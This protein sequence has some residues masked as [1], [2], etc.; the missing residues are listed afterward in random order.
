MLAFIFLLIVSTFAKTRGFD[1]CFI[2]TKTPSLLLYRNYQT[3]STIHRNAFK[4][5]VSSKEI[6]LPNQLQHSVANP[7]TRDVENIKSPSYIFEFL[8]NL[9]NMMLNAIG[10]QP[11]YGLSIVILTTLGKKIY[12]Y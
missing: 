10:L 12:H 1:S 11:T 9:V 2:K 4:K 8:I 3:K 6:K 7:T 5:S